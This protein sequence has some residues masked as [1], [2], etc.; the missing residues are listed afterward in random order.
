MGENIVGYFRSGSK[1]GR[2]TT[3]LAAMPKPPK[4]P[5]QLAD[6]LLLHSG[7]DIEFELF[8]LDPRVPEVRAFAHER[9]LAIKQEVDR[10]FDNGAPQDSTDS[11]NFALPDLVGGHRSNDAV[12]L[13]SMLYQ[14]LRVIRDFPLIA[15]RKA[16]EGRPPASARVN[17][18]V[19]AIAEYLKTF[20]QQKFT[21][22]I[23]SDE[24]GRKNF[25]SRAAHLTKE[26]SLCLNLGFS[27]TELGTS[28]RQ[29]R[30]E[31][32]Q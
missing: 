7:Y 11:F 27:D 6:L 13:G 3:R 12:E 9:L 29:V 23:E 18:L 21:V 20:E 22:D 30:D 17:Q 15:D 16:F 2:L 25:K 4:F 14:A 32:Q 10:L 19:R 31:L 26:V 28:L 5:Q 8:Q 24:R 1:L